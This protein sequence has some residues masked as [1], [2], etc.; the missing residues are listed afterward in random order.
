MDKTFIYV[1]LGQDFYVALDIN[2][3]IIHNI[4]VLTDESQKEYQEAIDQVTT[5]KNSLSGGNHEKTI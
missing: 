3:N 2:G 5:F 1:I 4:A